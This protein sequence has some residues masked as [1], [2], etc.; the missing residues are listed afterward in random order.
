MYYPEDEKLVSFARSLNDETLLIVA[1]WSNDN[2]E[3]VLP[4]DLQ[5]KTLKLF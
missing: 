1:N 2:I 5:A 4:N 3:F